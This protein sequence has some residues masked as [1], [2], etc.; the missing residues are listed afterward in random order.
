MRKR[1]LSISLWILSI[2][3]YLNAQDFEWAHTFGGTI[4]DNG[5]AIAVDLSLI[6]I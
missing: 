4:S 2:G 3:M 1:I 6:H 5:N